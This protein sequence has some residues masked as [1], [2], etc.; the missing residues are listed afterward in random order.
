MDDYGPVIIWS[1]VAFAIGLIT[2][3]IIFAAMKLFI[4]F[5]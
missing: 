5:F 4:Y 3:T 2:Y 1:L